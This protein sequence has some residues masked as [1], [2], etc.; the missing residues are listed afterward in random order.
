[1]AAIVEGAPL[2]LAR[3]HRQQRRRAL[4]RGSEICGFSSTQK[5]TA[6]SGGSTYSPTMSRT[7]STSHGS[8]DSLMRRGAPGRGSLARP[9]TRSARNR[10]RHLQTVVGDTCRRLAMP[11]VGWPSAQARMMRAR[12]ASCGALRERCASEVR[13]CRSSSVSVTVAGRASS[14]HA[15]LSLGP[16]GDTGAQILHFFQ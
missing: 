2:G 3:L 16:H 13:C 7:L 11:V 9:S 15:S 10:V 6:C 12:R 8:G 1:M 5:T 4:D 14:S